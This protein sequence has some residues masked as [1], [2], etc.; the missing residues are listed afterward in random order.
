MLKDVLA[1]SGKG[2]LFKLVSSTNSAVIVE[3]MSDGK[4][5]P[6]FASSKVGSLEDVAIYT[7]TEEVPLQ[8][9]FKA[10]HERGGGKNVEIP[11]DNNEIKKLMEEV[12]PN[13]DKNR[14]YVSDMRKLFKWY[15]D[16]NERNILK[17]EKQATPEAE[18]K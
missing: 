13:Y 12:L 9:V 16:L 5:F 18:V 17:F 14:V 15:N 2:G 10:I 11:K 6:V 7:Q 4:R 8:D 1:I 3:S